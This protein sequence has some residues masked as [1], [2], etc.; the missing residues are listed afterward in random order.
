MR[1]LSVFPA[2]VFVLLVLILP[3][4]AAETQTPQ[5]NKI[6]ITAGPAQDQHQNNQNT[7][8]VTATLIPTSR[9]TPGEVVFPVTRS[10][11]PP[12]TRQETPPPSTLP[13]TTERETTPPRTV[14]PTPPITIPV[15]QFTTVP[16]VTVTVLVYPSGPV[17][18]PNYYYPYGYS[19]PVDYY[20][21]AGSLTVT[22]NPSGA[23]VILDGYNYGSTPYMFTGLT[24]GYHTVEV[25]YPGY[26][27]YITNVYMDTGA[28]QQIYADLASLV[29]AGSLFID[30][31]PKG[32]DVYV[33]GNYQG[34]SPVTVSGV[35]A[36]SHQVELHRAGYEVLTSTETVT[37]GQG[38]VVNLVMVPYSS[39][40]GSGSIDITSNIPGA[41]VYLDGIYKG[42]TPSGT[43][44][45]IIAVS[46]GPHMVL[47]HLP[48]YTDITQPVQVSAGQIADIN[49]VFTPSSGGQQGATP[50]SPATGSVIVTS[51]PSGGQV[52]M[53]NQFRGITPVTIYNAAP[54]THIINMQL[55][56]YSDW[57]ASVDVPANQVVQVPATL[58]PASGTAPVPTRAGLSAVII[59]GALAICVVVMSVR[60]RR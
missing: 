7:E 46:P 59:I 36:G 60:I 35:V 51:S 44:Y 26:E 54:G 21:P 5:E 50:A 27:A 47:L 43:I 25:D 34:T 39:S 33:D 29:S 15:T 3:V 41:L 38:T 45:N 22:S 40:S 52:Y 49:A 30:S 57:S 10:E 17:Y 8:R 2:L 48:G 11:T 31:T 32:A 9:P 20:N 18:L 14:T 24:T 56:G 55:A 12:P 28:S 16:V 13:R 37:A 58:T 6:T 42:T 19:Y 4:F 23:V 53:D 1:T